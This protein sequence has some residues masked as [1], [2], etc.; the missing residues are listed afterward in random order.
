MWGRWVRVVRW[1]EYEWEWL[2]S[3]FEERFWPVEARGAA[4]SANFELYGRDSEEE[5]W[6][7][8]SEWRREQLQMALDS[9]DLLIRRGVES[10]ASTLAERRKRGRSRGSGI[11]TLVR[12]LR[13]VEEIED[14]PDV[15]WI[16]RESELDWVIEMLQ[17]WGDNARERVRE[18]Y[19]DAFESHKIACRYCNGG[20]PPELRSAIA[21][22]K[23]R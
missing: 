21:R 9:A 1:T 5:D 17:S 7:A 22:H 14:Y 3:K 11:G 15:L 12:H 16:L 2:V 6:E 20:L 13:D 4:L 23:S 10:P 18:A 8:V 19:A